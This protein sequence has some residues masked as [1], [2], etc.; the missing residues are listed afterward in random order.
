LR[1]IAYQISFPLIT[2]S[3]I[4]FSSNSFFWTVA[5]GRVSITCP[6][7]GLFSHPSLFRFMASDFLIEISYPRNFAGSCA[8]VIRVFPSESSSFSLSLMKIV[9][10]SFIFTQSSLLPITP[11]RKSSA[12]LIYLSLLYVL[13]IAIDAETLRVMASA[14]FNW[15]SNSLLASSSV[16]FLI[17]LRNLIA[18]R[19]YFAWSGFSRLFLPL[20]NDSAYS[21][22][23]LSNLS[24]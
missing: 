17:A 9:K 7:N 4:A 12:Y 13:S 5:I 15:E 22:M 10:S 20:S 19:L 3:S 23:Y 16:A 14:S 18:L 8:F 1:G 11:I 2:L 6:L 24:R 21:R